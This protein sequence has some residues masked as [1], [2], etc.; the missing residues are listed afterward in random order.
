MELKARGNMRMLRWTIPVLTILT[1]AVSA[2]ALEHGSEDTQNG[3]P[4]NGN[5]PDAKQGTGPLLPTVLDLRTAQDIAM[6]QNP[7]LQAAEARVSQAKARVWQA[8]SAYFPQLNLS[9]SASKTW[10]SPRDYDAARDAAVQ[11]FLDQVYSETQSGFAAGSM[12]DAQT[13]AS[14]F[15]SGW[16]GTPLLDI[17][18]RRPQAFYQ[19]GQG[20]SQGLYPAS[21]A[22]RSI[23]NSI[24]DYRVGLTLSYLIFNGFERK[25]IN[26]QARFGM[27]ETE[28]A[29]AEAKRLLLDAVAQTYYAA[30]L[31]RENV[32]IAEADKAF[33][34]R[35]LKEAQARR[36]VGA[37]SLSD[38]LN[39]E[40]ARN[41][42]QASLIRARRQFEVALI[43]LAELLA[44]PDDLDP[45]AIR[46][47]ELE[48]ESPE[49]LERPDP[50]ALAAYAKDNRP[51]LLLDAYTV[52]RAEAG[53]GAQ[54]AAFYPVVTAFVSQDAVRSNSIQ[55]DPTASNDLKFREDDFSTT[56]GINVTYELFAGGRNIA[57]LNEAKAFV[58]EAE[59]NAH[60]TKLTVTADVRQAVQELEAAQELLLLERNNAQLVQRNRDLVERGYNEGAESLVRLNEAQRDLI[61]A[62]ASLAAARVSLFQAWHDVRTATGESI[63]PYISGEL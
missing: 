26:A 55:T 15:A 48:V 46:L 16:Q 62:R 41:A 4:S 54:R 42:A 52:Q 18:T 13:Y 38:E 40:V 43:G 12:S 14:I 37:G 44:L 5:V 56:A 33:N 17:L 35:L 53:V 39:F 34:A 9:A 8:R 21:Q 2:A 32:N 22:R 11:P 19:L 60:Q 7:S 47:A 3:V 57:E 51:E 1:V 20:L 24:Q 49:V 36:R 29:L 25:F 27:K 28:A 50:A 45:T 30:Q 23:D 31:A 6:S 59:R 10:L 63:E 61:Q 58:R